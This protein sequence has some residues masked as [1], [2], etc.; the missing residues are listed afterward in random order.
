MTGGHQRAAAAVAPVPV[1][2]AK[3]SAAVA[4]VP[5]TSTAGGPGA[6]P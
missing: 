5:P 3:V 2:V 6:R 4:R 1:T